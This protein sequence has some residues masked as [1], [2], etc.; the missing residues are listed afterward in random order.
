MKLII[1]DDNI[2]F[3]KAFK[4]LLEEEYHCN[5]I[6]EADTGEA[7]LLLPQIADANLIFLDLFMPGKNGIE[8]ARVALKNNQGLQFIAVTM[9]SEKAYLQELKD[10]G[11]RGVIAKP[12][13]FDELSAAM[14]TVTRGLC[15]FP[16]KETLKKMSR[17]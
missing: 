15:Y 12:R 5:V 14:Q 13:L 10:S 1:V 8:I 4:K 11:F 9:H 17:I 7:F 2:S 3:R 6:G 16:D